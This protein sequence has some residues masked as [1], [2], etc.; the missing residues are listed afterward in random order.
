MQSYLFRRLAYH[1]SCG[2]RRQSVVML[3]PAFVAASMSSWTG[4]IVPRIMPGDST[5][6]ADTEA[7]SIQA[8]TAKRSIDPCLLCPERGLKFHP[9][10]PGQAANNSTTT[11]NLAP[12]SVDETSQSILLDVYMFPPEDSS[13]PLH[14]RMDRS[15]QEYAN[16]T[17]NRM[18]LSVNKQ[19]AKRQKKQKG[20]KQK[21]Q[22]S[23][24]SNN[25]TSDDSIHIYKIPSD[26]PWDVENLTN[27][28]VWTQN[29]KTP[30]P[31]NPKTPKP[32]F[33]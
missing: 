6:Q 24:Q 29:P 16:Q 1:H 33:N 7:K 9:F 21:V 26:T 15:S 25:A 17:L 11:T 8:A 3:N 12:V 19:M 27:Q 14:I 31:Q 23:K 18:V 22:K 13:T 30:K 5:S 10:A 20:K 4:W 2:K 32:L 28:Q